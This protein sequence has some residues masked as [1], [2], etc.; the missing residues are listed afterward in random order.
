MTNLQ[1][2]LIL[3]LF[4]EGHSSKEIN[5]KFLVKIYQDLKDNSV[6]INYITINKEK[7]IF[8]NQY[9]QFLKKFFKENK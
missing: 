3:K 6:I 1:R 4:S 2:V 7:I 5:E 8:G 9:A